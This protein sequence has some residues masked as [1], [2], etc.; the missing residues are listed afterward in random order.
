MTS[1]VG[2]CNIALARIGHEPFISDLSEDS[3]AARQ[4]NVLY[5]QILDS[6]LREYIWR[7]SIKRVTLA[8]TTETP[9]F[10]GGNYFN[11][12]SDFIRVIGTSVDDRYSYKPWSVEGNKIRARDESFDLVYC[13]RIEDTSLYDTIFIDALANRLGME[14]C[15][16]LVRDSGVKQTMFDLYDRSV[17]KAAYVSATEHDSTTILSEQ[18]LRAR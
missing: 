10:D 9:A 7:F 3:K 18:F 11:L 1:K 4:C 16:S 15:G 8:K 6:L 13:A 17:R 5:P 12:P 14:L 2:I